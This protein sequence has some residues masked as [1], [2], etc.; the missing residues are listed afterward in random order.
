METPIKA[1][2]YGSVTAH[3]V[4]RDAV[5]AMAFYE[6]VF[7]AKEL[8]RL[9]MPG[10]S[11]AHA[12]FKIGDTIVMIANENP[13]WGNKSPATLGGSP[14]VLNVAVADPDAAAAKA[15]AHGGKV[16]VPV[17]DH[18]YG[19]RAGRIEDPSG[20]LWMVSKMLEALSPQEMQRRMVAMFA[21]GPHK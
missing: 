18:F 6:A 19:F 3:L 14:I 5:A 1:S 8:Y 4:V 13:N 21:G 17:Q 11:I 15:E 9:T 20:H 16:L 12:E 7:G 10:G 2:D